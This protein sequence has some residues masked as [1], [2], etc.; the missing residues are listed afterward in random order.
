MGAIRNLSVDV[1]DTLQG[2]VKVNTI[3]IYSSTPGISQN[4]Y[5]WTGIYFQNAPVTLVAQTK[6]GY[7]FLRW[8]E[9]NLVVGTSPTL[10]L[11]MANSRNVVAEFGPSSPG[12]CVSLG[13]GDWHTANTWDC[14]RV[15]NATDM[16]TVGNGHVVTVGTA[17]AEA[18]SLELRGN[19]NLKISNNRD[20]KLLSVN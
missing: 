11:N 8:K 5:P 7:E 10:V 2:Y 1:S 14:G 19:G 20:L 12:V 9:N 3:K 6:A 18:K 13:S 15:P 17:N 16:V 4:P